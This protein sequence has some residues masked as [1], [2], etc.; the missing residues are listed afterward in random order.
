MTS[1]RIS[2][3]K[4]LIAPLLV[5]NL[6][7]AALTYWLAWIPAQIAFDQSL[8][9]AAW[10]L[11]PHLRM[12]DG[13]IETEL[14]NQAEEVL[15]V[16]HFDAIYLM[17]RDLAGKTILGDKDFPLHCLPSTFNEPMAC[18]GRMR[19]EAVRIITL[20]TEIGSDQV[21]I[22][23]AETLRKRNVIRSE[24][25]GVL[26]L[27]EGLLVAVSVALIWIAVAKGLWPLHIMR[28]KLIQ[29][30]D[31]DLSALPEQDAPVEVRPFVNAINKLLVRAQTSSTAQ[32]DFLANVAHQLRTPL[33]GLK[34]QL[35]WLQNKHAEE[36]ETAQSAAL[37][38]SSVD[39]M[40]RQ[41]NQLLA[42]ARAEP[43]QFEKN[44]LSIVALDKLVEE[45]IQHFVQ[46]ADKKGID[47]GFEL[48]PTKVMGDKFLLRDLIDNLID[49]AI[50]YSPLKGEV[51]V[52]C[53]PGAAGGHFVVEDSGPGIPAQHRE[54]IFNRFF[55][56]DET[57]AG[58]GLGL[59]IVHDI[60]MDHG[61]EIYLRQRKNGG[62]TIFDVEF[63]P[64][65]E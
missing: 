7:G 41:S 13:R 54:K 1:I 12:V 21:V 58:N 48:L 14:S 64:S 18:D 50:R 52:R 59:A 30:R 63:P 28:G 22:G 34:T 31:D 37:M 39:R 53:F 61:A 3:L 9:D 62:G 36:P 47:L 4:W 55:R 25:I 49:N 15:R 11:I 5:L 38:Q 16:D 26:L 29:R 43:S 56:L 17:A 45:S 8:A 6:G 32:Q 57:Q 65:S 46:E 40:I 35:E 20:R 10:A 33:A 27:L 42:L 19:G 51:T 60:A 24:I 2:L 23:A 44:R